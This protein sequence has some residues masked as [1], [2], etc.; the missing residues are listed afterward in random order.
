MV[1][2]SLH[3]KDLIDSINELEDYFE[4][5]D[6]KDL[7]RVKFAKAKLKGCAKIWWQEV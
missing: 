4:Y 5:E 2:S 7:D 3:P 6:I 1:P